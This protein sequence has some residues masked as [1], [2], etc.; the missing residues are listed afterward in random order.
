MPSIALACLL[1]VLMALGFWQLDRAEQKRQLT[2][3]QEQRQHVEMIK[4]TADS[5]DSVDDLLYRSVQLIGKFDN[6]HHILQ[7]NQISDGKPG[8]FVFTPLVMQNSENAILVNRGWIPY[9]SS[10]EA[11]PNLNLS[12]GESELMGQ[13]NRFSRPGIVLSGA[14]K[15]TNSS[16]TI[17]QVINTGE[18]A[19]KLGYSLFSYQVELDIS[20]AFGFKRDWRHIQAMPP[21]K[22]VAYAV[23]WFLLALTLIVLF[24]VYGV[25]KDDGKS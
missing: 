20:F 19:K 23:Q 1:P 4:L 14:D 13:V 17:V 10:A 21:E 25:N 11:L 2:L 15:P 3:L 22:H 6:M 9:P 24:I 8:Y 18:L 5:P 12:Q 16:P 7:D